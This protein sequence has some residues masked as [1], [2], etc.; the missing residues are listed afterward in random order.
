MKLLIQL[1]LY[2]CGSQKLRGII[3][4]SHFPFLPSLTTFDEWGW[5]IFVITGGI[6]SVPKYMTQ[7]LKVKLHEYL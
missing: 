1:Y 4:Q 2:I 7:G 3:Y 5:Q 6:E